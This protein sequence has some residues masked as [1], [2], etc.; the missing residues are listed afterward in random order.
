[1]PVSCVGS[2]AW[3]FRDQLAEAAEAEGFR[4]GKILQSPIEGLIEYH[5]L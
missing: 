2:I 1:M 4:L 5:N 3:H